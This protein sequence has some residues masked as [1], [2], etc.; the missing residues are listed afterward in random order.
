MIGSISSAM[1]EVYLAKE[2]LRKWNQHNAERTGKL[3]LLVEW[4]T[5]EEDLQNVDMVIGIVGNWIDNAGIIERCVEKGKKVILFFNAFQD[6]SNTIRSE[7]EEVRS[8]CE[9]IQT[10]CFTAHFKGGTELS[11]LLSNQFDVL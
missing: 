6:T 9:R 4:T 5:N 10:K 3:F 1:E 7:F 8:F 2:A 11:S